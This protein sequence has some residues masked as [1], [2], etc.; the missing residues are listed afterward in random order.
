MR[1]GQ[2]IVGTTPVENK[3]PF[4]HFPGYC[5]W[6]PKP[7]VWHKELITETEAEEKKKKEKAGE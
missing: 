3:K 6:L 4:K 1:S 7:S 5:T 2:V